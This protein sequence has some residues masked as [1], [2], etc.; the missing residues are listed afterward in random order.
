MLHNV[1]LPVPAAVALCVLLF[2]VNA[3]AQT[4]RAK[5]WVREPAHV[6]RALPLMLKFRD[7]LPEEVDLS[8]K[9]P[10]PGNQGQQSSCTAWATGYAMRSYYEG[11]RR[12]WNFSS[13]G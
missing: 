4:K 2:C 13:P 10:T 1:R 11:R 9:F 12:N 3:Q 6:V 5:G 7:Y 8:T